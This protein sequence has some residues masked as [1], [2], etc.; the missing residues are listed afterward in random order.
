MNAD[1]IV[2]DE[3]SMVGEKIGRELLSLGRPVV[4]VGDP[5]QL[6][7]VKAKPFFRER[8]DYLLEKV[9]RFAEDSI[10]TR[11][12]RRIREDFWVRGEGAVPMSKV[13]FE[14][15]KKF[16]QVIV[17]RNATRRHY[18]RLYRESMGKKQPFPEVGERLIC[19]K[20][21]AVQVEMQNGTVWEVLS[22]TDLGGEL[23]LDLTDGNTSVASNL[24]SK[25]PF[26]EDEPILWS[27][28]DNME[29]F[30]YAYA[31]TAHK[32][33]GSQWPNVFV[34]DEGVSFRQDRWRWLYTAVTRAE[35][36]VLVGTT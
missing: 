15:T 21:S 4:A 5:F 18:N 34:K 27:E 24:V 22:V 1:L 11:V 10:V 2:I 23:V 30:D 36:N 8:A 13:T 9:H 16:D 29:F 25:A 6:P 17:G 7:P 19:L 31:I 26:I 12:S 32:A 35:Q 3:C 14:D 28:H 33:Q 20:N